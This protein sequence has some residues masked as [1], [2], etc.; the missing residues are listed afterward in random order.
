M[1]FTYFLFKQDLKTPSAVCSANQLGADFEEIRPKPDPIS[2][3]VATQVRAFLGVH[4]GNKPDW[5]SFADTQFALPAKYDPT[6]RAHSLVIFLQ[7]AGRMFAITAGRGWM[8]ID[9]DIIELAF[10][11][12]ILLNWM[13][14]E[15]IMM[16]RSRSTGKGAKQREEIRFAK[17]SP[18]ELSLSDRVAVL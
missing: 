10:G 18:R 7:T 8:R 13:E 15:Q 2:G 5:N 1:Q 17:G 4:D 12:T 11:R 6:N 9:K 3:K 16:L 14:A